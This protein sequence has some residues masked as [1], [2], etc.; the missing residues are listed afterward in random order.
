MKK[1]KK[2]KKILYYEEVTLGTRDRVICSKF[3]KANTID[4]EISKI[5]HKNGYC[6]RTIFYDIRGY[7]YDIRYCGIC[8]KILGC[9]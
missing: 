1:K 4:I 3:R 6:D 8:N 2:K 9:I 7:L 5:S